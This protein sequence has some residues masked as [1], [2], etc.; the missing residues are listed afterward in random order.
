MGSNVKLF[1]GCIAVR[2]NM[3]LSA[4]IFVKVGPRV[5]TLWLHWSS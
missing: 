5:I 3:A 1:E 4:D 2:A